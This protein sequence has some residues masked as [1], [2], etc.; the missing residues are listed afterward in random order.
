MNQ[1]D[2][3]FN[4][5]AQGVPSHL[6]IIISDP[7]QNADDVV[8]VNLTDADRYFDQ[9]CVLD[10]SDHPGVISKK[11]CVAFQLAKIT[12]TAALNA[13]DKAALLFTRPP[14]PIATLNKILLAVQTA[15][16]LRNAPKLVL[17]Q[18]GF[19]N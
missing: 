12:S 13:A 14:V 17:I 5:A 19:I 15:D 6:W 4:K 3:F 18:Q 1:G 16:E 8:I 9:T 7:T 2:C 10:V 11:S